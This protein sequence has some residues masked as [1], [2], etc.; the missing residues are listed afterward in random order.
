MAWLSIY[1]PVPC[2]DWLSAEWWVSFIRPA[3][4]RPLHDPVELHQGRKSCRLTS[5]RTTG[6]GL[7]PGCH[8]AGFI[9]WL[10]PHKVVGAVAVARGRGR[11]SPAARMLIFGQ[12]HLRAILAQY[13]AHYNERRPIAA[14]SSTRPG[15]TTLP[16]TSPRSESGV[17][18]SLAALSANTSEPP[19]AQV[20]TGGR[21]LEPHPPHTP[22]RAPRWLLIGQ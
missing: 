17:G 15:P 18:P 9:R 8:S 3:C 4:V 2:W 22:C 6:S 1:R 21:V 20:R 13:E 14:A 10:P 16:P 7:W 11:R 19:K 5:Q 12:R